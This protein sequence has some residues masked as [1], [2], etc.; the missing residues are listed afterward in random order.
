MLET[1]R[2]WYTPAFGTLGW[3]IGFW[4]LIGA[5]GFTV[6]FPL[7][8]FGIG[9]DSVAL[10]MPRFCSRELRRTISVVARNVLGQVRSNTMVPGLPE[11]DIV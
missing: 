1:Q 11:T 9:T 7:S 4:N 6:R 10:W 5:F 3:H 2:K 8:G